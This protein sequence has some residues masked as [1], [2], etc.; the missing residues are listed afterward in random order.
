MVLLSYA[1][2]ERG[3]GMEVRKTTSWLTH[4]VVEVRRESLRVLLVLLGQASS[5]RIERSRVVVDLG[6]GKTE[7]EVEEE[8]QSMEYALVLREG[9][10][11]SP[12]SDESLW[13][14]VEACLVSQVLPISTSASLDHTAPF[15]DAC[16]YTWNRLHMSVIP[17]S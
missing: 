3:E 17:T 7:D 15:N 6:D 1:T 4:P 13:E 2:E 12:V 11:V 10:E 8:Y 9:G 5:Q 16:V 14:A